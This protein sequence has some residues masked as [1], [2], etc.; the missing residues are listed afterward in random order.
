MPWSKSHTLSV[1]EEVAA[2]EVERAVRK[3]EPEAKGTKP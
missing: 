2:A 1:G 3:E